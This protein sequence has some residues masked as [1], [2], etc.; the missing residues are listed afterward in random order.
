MEREYAKSRESVVAEVSA[1]LAH[2]GEKFTFLGQ[3]QHDMSLLWDDLCRQLSPPPPRTHT[4]TTTPFPVHSH[5]AR[6]LKITC[7]RLPAIRN[8][9]FSQEIGA[10]QWW[11]GTV[12]VRI[13]LVL[14]PLADELKI[15]SFV[16]YSSCDIKHSKEPQQS[17]P[18][19]T[20][21]PA[22]F[23]SHISPTL[24]NLLSLCSHT[25]A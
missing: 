8:V 10:R 11:W 16:N 7:C 9:I 1:E 15:L 21:T 6:V 3:L 23:P 13:W 25:N 5:R 20:H 12:A 4:Y 17:D 24:L 22:C 2:E 19:P 18:P 14:L